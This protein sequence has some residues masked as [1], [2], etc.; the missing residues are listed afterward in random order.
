MSDI[1]RHSLIAVKAYPEALLRGP[2]G[3]NP[4]SSVHPLHPMRE[5]PTVLV[6]SLR[7]MWEVAPI[8]IDIPSQNDEGNA[9]IYAFDP[10]NIPKPV[11]PIRAEVT[12]GW[13]F[14]IAATTSITEELVLIDGAIDVVK[15][16]LW[17]RVDAAEAILWFYILASASASLIPP[18]PVRS[19]REL[20]ALARTF[21]SRMAPHFIFR[22]LVRPIAY[23]AAILENSAGI[24]QNSDY[25]ELQDASGK[26]TIIPVAAEYYNTMSELVIVYPVWLPSL[27]KRYIYEIESVDLVVDATMEKNVRRVTCERYLAP[28]LPKFLYYDYADQF[29][30]PSVILDAS[31]ALNEVASK[32]GT[33]TL[34]N[35]EHAAR[36]A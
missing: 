33:D 20:F 22:A 2:D 12:N 8:A 36:V 4:L 29:I 9:L 19:F 35:L 16:L 30:I 28:V 34:R 26:I 25:T 31:E 17:R 7:E 24:A 3:F 15:G 11:L 32:Y 21:L 14:K 18:Y 10:Y 5:M 6:N 27:C 1:G 23:G 13:P